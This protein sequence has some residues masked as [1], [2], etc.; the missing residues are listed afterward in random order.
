MGVFDNTSNRK[1]NNAKPNYDI[2]DGVDIVTCDFEACKNCKF[3]DIK[4]NRC[5]FETC[6]LN[7]FPYSIPFHN[8]QTR[9][10]I[11]CDNEFT[12]EFNESEYHPLL[13]D[14]ITVCDKCKSKLRNLIV[15]NNDE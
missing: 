7:Q 2:D 10:C 12:I 5:V 13:S 4:F 6:I 11:I 15:G 3:R 1:Y 14:S 9:N 8:T